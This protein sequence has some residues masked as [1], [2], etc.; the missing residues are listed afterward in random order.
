[1]WSAAAE[2]MGRCVFEGSLSMCDTDI[3]RRPY[4]RDCKLHCIRRQENAP[5]LLQNR[6]M[7]HFLKDNLAPNVPFLCIVHQVGLGKAS[8]RAQP[9]IRFHY[10]EI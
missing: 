8:L 7:F 4:H 5:T 2:M 10:I 3:E 9:T 1:M 6:V